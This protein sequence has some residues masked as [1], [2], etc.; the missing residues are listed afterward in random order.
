MSISRLNGLFRIG[1]SATNKMA[2]KT[3]GADSTYSTAGGTA[4]EFTTD[5]TLTFDVVSTPIVYRKK[6]RDLTE[7]GRIGF[8]GGP[9]SALSNTASYVMVG[10]GAG[11]GGSHPAGDP[12]GGGGGGSGGGLRGYWPTVVP[13]PVADPQA[14]AIGPSDSGFSR[15]DTTKEAIN[16]A[17]VTLTVDIGAAGSGGPGTGNNGSN[18]NATTFS[19]PGP[20]KAALGNPTAS[21]DLEGAAGGYGGAA[22]TG[23]NAGPGSDDTRNGGGA[24]CYA[25]SPG[26]NGGGSG[27]KGNP[28]G[29]THPGYQSQPGGTG[30]GGG[31]RGSAG[32]GSSGGTGL[33]VTVPGRPAGTSLPMGGG[34]GGAGRGGING[35]THGNRWPGTNNGSGGS[36][37]GGNGGGGTPS[38]AGG[39]GGGGGGGRSPNA[40]GAGSNGIAIIVL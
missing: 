16:I 6:S 27:P 28:G 9:P 35:P 31:G 14:Y 37:G 26:S 30:G 19:L 10:G 25:P 17:G 12:Q 13:D 33:T 3:N 36:G 1:R 23:G 4:Y 2:L 40:G 34:G 39:Y 7:R 8:D 38:N 21:N 32:S 5:G 24:G 18:G 11:G 15:F 29:S 22:P 20:Y